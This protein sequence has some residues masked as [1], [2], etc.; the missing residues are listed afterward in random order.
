MSFLCEC[1]RRYELIRWTSKECRYYLQCAYVCFCIVLFFSV[2]VWVCGCCFSISAYAFNQ[3]LYNKIYQM[4]GITSSPRC[5]YTGVQFSDTP[6]CAD[7]IMFGCFV[8]FFSE[9]RGEEKGRVRAYTEV[10]SVSC[11][12]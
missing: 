7:C 6:V 2:C 8:F 12:L 1:V 3:A 4:P 10:L 5:A 11:A 9:R